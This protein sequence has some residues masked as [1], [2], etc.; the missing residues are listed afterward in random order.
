MNVRKISACIWC[1]I[2]IW[3]SPAWSQ[4]QSNSNDSIELI[5][6]RF[7][8][9]HGEK[10]GL[11]ESLPILEKMIKSDNPKDKDI[12]FSCIQRWGWQLK[13]RH[14]VEMLEGSYKLRSEERRVGKECA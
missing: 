12:A 11:S 14:L 9:I 8:T 10:V 13:G 3:L 4:P 5:R 1:M 6:Y 7:V 2:F